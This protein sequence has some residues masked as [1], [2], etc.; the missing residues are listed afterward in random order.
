[1]FSIYL[2]ASLCEFLGS[3]F[4]NSIYASRFLTLVHL[5]LLLFAST[6]IHQKRQR[7][8]FSSPVTAMPGCKYRFT[9][10]AP[11][12]PRSS[13]PAPPALRN[14]R[15]IPLTSLHMLSETFLPSTS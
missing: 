10:I 11:L 12:P 5:L 7:S 6:P 3:R 8:T 4:R 1:Y 15:A 14:L 2:P 9:G 13:S